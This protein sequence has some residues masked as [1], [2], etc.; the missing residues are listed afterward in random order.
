MSIF[1]A[2]ELLDHHSCDRLAFLRLRQFRNVMH[3]DAPT[4]G[5][6]ELMTFQV[7]DMGAH[8][9]KNS[10]PSPPFFYV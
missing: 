9:N 2:E 10:Y 3:H 5:K 4:D 7:S 1:T 6:F 8:S